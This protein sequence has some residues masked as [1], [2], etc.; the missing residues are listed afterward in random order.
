[1]IFIIGAAYSGKEA[2]AKKTFGNDIK[3]IRDIHILVKKAMERGDSP[4]DEI[5]M[6]T[7]KNKDA[8]FISNEV[9]YGIVPTDDFERRWR[10]ECGRINCL[11]AKEADRVFR[12]VCGI[13][14]VIK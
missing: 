6:L 14:T 8:I 7:E 2:Y 12:V 1:M 3:I 9:G 5:A 11:L 13:G 4:Y 10:E